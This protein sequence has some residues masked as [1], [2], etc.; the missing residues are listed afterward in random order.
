MFPQHV[1]ARPRE[2]VRESFGGHNRISLPFLA[3]VETLGLRA[4]AQRKACRF[5]ECP[6]EVLVAILGVARAFFLIIAL[7]QALNAPTVGTEIAHLGEPR[8][9]AGLEHD[10]RRQRLPDSRHAPQERI[11]LA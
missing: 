8:D 3:F 6:G 4:V 2:L 5:H 10:R 7:P 1:I 11:V 9:V